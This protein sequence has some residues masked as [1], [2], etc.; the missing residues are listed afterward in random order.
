M[1]L[2]SLS[3]SGFRGFASSVDLDLDA[4]AVVIVGA[5]GS[6]KTSLFDAILWAL[7]G[8]VPRLD[9][10]EETL[11]SRFSPTGE[12]RV[13]LVLAAADGRPLQVT[14]RWDG[15]TT[16]SIND[17]DDQLRGPSAE[18]RLLERL[19]PDARTASNPRDAF[20]RALT[21]GVY[22]QQDLLRQFL[23]AD[24]EQ[25][26]FVVVGEMVGT[27]RVAELQRQLETGKTNWT[28]STNVLATELQPLEARRA[29]I[30][31]RLERLGDGPAGA[32]AAAGSWSDWVTRARDYV[33]VPELSG[34]SQDAARVLD[35]AL[36]ELQALQ[37]QIERRVGSIGQ[38]AGHLNAG[39]PQAVATDPLRLAV[40]VAEKSALDVRERLRLAQEQAAA[41]RRRQTETRAAADE[42]KTLAQLAL[43]HLGEN[44]PVCS[45]EY[46]V[47]ATQERLEQLLRDEGGSTP[48]T[49][50]DVGSLAAEAEASERAL[51]E[52]TAALRQGEQ[53]AHALAEWQRTRDQLVRDAGLSETDDL[54]REA[55]AAADALRARAEGIQELRNNG[56]EL[57]L[58]LAR[59][60]EVALRA[61]LERELA[62]L[63]PEIAARAAAI[64]SRG[65]T[66]EIAAEIAAALR[67]ANSEI[68]AAEL[69]RV[70]PVL[71]RIYATVDPHPAFRAVTFLTKTVRGRG[72][73]WATLDDAT[74]EVT[75]N[76]PARVLSSSQVNVL[77]LSVFL[78]LNLG[79]DTLPLDVVGLDDP[80]QSLDDVNLLGFVDLLRRMKGRRQILV[81]THDPKLGALLSR[82]L[83]PVSETERARLITLEGWTRDGP[84]VIQDDVPR[85]PK[86]LRLVA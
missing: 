12:A 32:E 63:Q 5:N 40:A 48:E 53:A 85:D 11:L 70:A 3:I 23:D 56:D 14:R 37:L 20:A 71:Q 59:T 82:K 28:R 79:I 69:Q 68:V 7:S 2:K 36:K 84:S 18:A 15:E 51:A 38:L 46:D 9:G 35:G 29:T 75:V 81:S 30:L 78:A 55:A 45:Q 21:R 86:R 60:G 22:L 65:E 42:L 58:Q 6:G 31:Q 4:D 17:D 26:R 80:L 73:L 16:V 43:R 25:Q 72:R 61:Q 83:R 52:A 64:L 57:S 8:T 77:A 34:E 10:G 67:E 39:P 1:R 47:V 19:W 54:V 76:E 13:E 66:G 27:G 44:C 33:A 50:I 49:V 74:A 41:Q 62:S 24:D